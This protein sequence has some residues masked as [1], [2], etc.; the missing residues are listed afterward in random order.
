[1]MIF[2]SSR[3][4]SRPST[5]QMGR[6]A[7]TLTC[8][9]SSRLIANAGVCHVAIFPQPIGKVRGDLVSNNSAYPTND[10]RVDYGNSAPKLVASILA[11]LTSLG[12]R[13]VV[14]EMDFQSGSAC[15]VPIT[16]SSIGHTYH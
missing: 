1:M 14:G 13:L 16:M 9:S 12:S 3:N 4:A 6:K 15:F 8:D 5:K 10:N 7:I 11:Y 2:R